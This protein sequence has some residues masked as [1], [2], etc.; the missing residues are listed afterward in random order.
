[1]PSPDETSNATRLDRLDGTPA[2]AQSAMDSELGCN[3]DKDW[4]PWGIGGSDIGALLGVSPYRC[5]VDVWLEKVSTGNG[6]APRSALPMR[7]GNFLEPFVV[8]EYERLTSYKTRRHDSTLHHPKHPEL[9]GHVDRIATMEHQTGDNSDG[10]STRDIVLECKT[11][12]AFR[13]KEWGPAWSD[14]V[15]AEYLAQCLWYLGL[16]NCEEAHLAVLLGNTDFRVYRIKRDRDIERHMFELAHSF[17]VE[18]VLT[19]RPP[20]AKTRAQAQS[21]HPTPDTGLAQQAGD[22]ALDAIKRKA[23]LEVELLEIQ[24]EIERLNDSVAV[25]M[26]AAERLTWQGKTLAT[27][28][29]SKGA[30]RLDGERLKR[31]RPDIVERYTV[32]GLATRRLQIYTNAL[33]QCTTPE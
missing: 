8:Q 16:A 10:V 18:H 9:F 20:H 26:G 32:N 24:A 3:D 15:P 33:T 12:S 6:A 11:C 19:K 5:A 27:W 17:W 23:Q 7:L 29:L 1:M 22:K 28:R 31:E 14:Q 21:L 2:P 4:R 30:A 25:S 13:A